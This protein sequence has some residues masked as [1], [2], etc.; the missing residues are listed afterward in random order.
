MQI[1]VEVVL[2]QTM[3]THRGVEI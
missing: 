2:V 1:K 3:K